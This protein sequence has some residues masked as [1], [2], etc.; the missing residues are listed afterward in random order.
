MFKQ[1]RQTHMKTLDPVG[2]G[3]VSCYF[4]VMG[5]MRD[6]LTFFLHKNT[7]NKTSSESSTTPV[8]VSTPATVTK[9][10]VVR[11]VMMMIMMINFQW[12]KTAKK[13]RKK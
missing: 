12:K 10:T 5:R 13:G 6:R 3:M 8:P 2:G 7:H 1:N 4:G 11:M 9:E